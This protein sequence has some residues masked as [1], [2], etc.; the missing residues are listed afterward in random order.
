MVLEAERIALAA[1]VSEQAAR[2]AQLDGA[3]RTERQATEGERLA[4]E[5]L[6]RQIAQKDEQRTK[7]LAE[8]Q[9]I[10]GRLA[11]TERELTAKAAEVGALRLDLEPARQELA[12]FESRERSMTAQLAESNEKLRSAERALVDAENESRIRGDELET[13]RESLQAEGFVATAQGEIERVPEPEID[14]EPT[15]AYATAQASGDLPPWLRSDDDGEPDLPPMRGGS[16]IDATQVRDRI[17]DLRATIRSLGPINEEAATE[18]ADSRE[19]FDFLSGQLN[20]LQQAEGQLNDAIVELEAEIRERFRTTFKTV[21]QE[22]ERYF[23]AF[24][25]GGTARLELGETDEYGLPGVE[26]VAQPPGKKL[27]SLALLSGGERSLTAVALLFA[28]L[29]ANPSPICVLDEVDAALDEANVGRFVEELRALSERTQ[30]IIITHN[31]RTIETADT[32]YG[33]SMGADNVSR[34]LSL[35]L[36]DVHVDE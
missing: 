23:S 32:I 8:A 30:F 17:A 25:R 11:T 31:R 22:F 18:Y 20:D 35:K 21:N 9:A 6:S 29:Q 34:I 3:F 36:E 26:I 15:E 13:L 4:R 14:V 27:G 12:Q 19:R 2:V 5:R 7:S 16:T 33:V 24:F 28:L 10:A 1:S